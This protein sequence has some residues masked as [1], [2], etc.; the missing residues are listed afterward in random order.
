M[1]STLLYDKEISV[2]LYRPPQATKPMYE[3][4][5][6]QGYQEKSLSGRKILYN[7]NIGTI[8]DNSVVGEALPQTASIE[9]YEGSTAKIF[10]GYGKD[11]SG[12]DVALYRRVKFSGNVYKVDT[13]EQMKQGR[14]PA[15]NT[16]MTGDRIYVRETKQTWTAILYKGGQALSYEETEEAWADTLTIAS[17]N[18]GLKP[19]ISMSISLLPGQ[20]CYGATLK[21]RNLNIDA[22]RIREWTRMEIT[23][24]Y[25]TGKKVKYICPIFTSYIESP[26]PDGVTVFEGITV[27]TAE[28][29]ITTQFI[30]L[31]F[32]QDEMTLY[33]L[34]HQVAPAISP[35]I[36]VNIMI[37]EKLLKEHK[38]KISKQTV[39]SQN[40]LAVLNWLQST[41]GA[42]VE[43]ITLRDYGE[44]TSIFMQL[45]DNELEII[46]LNGPNKMV[47]KVRST[48]NLDMVTGATFNGTALTVEAPWNP[49]LRPGGLFYMPP[50]FINGSRL[51]NV[52]PTS[53][54]R[55]DENLYRA[56][57]MSV[58]FGSVESTNKMTI[59]AV[60]AQ[61]S[62]ELP[63]H[64]TTNLTGESFARALAASAQTI[65][66]SRQ[67]GKADVDIGDLS[68]VTKD[69]ATN[70][71]MYDAYSEETLIAAWGSWTDVRINAGDSLSVILRRYLLE[72]LQGPRL[73]KGAK[74]IGNEEN[75]YRPITDF[76]N[77]AL[78][79]NHFSDNGCW[80]NAVWWPLVMVG[81]YWRW[82]RDVK[83]GVDNKWNTAGPDNPDLVKQD[84][85][86]YIPVFSTWAAMEAKLK[87]IKDIFK[88][89]YQE[90]GKYG[91]LANTW[92]T[93]YYYLGGTSD[94]G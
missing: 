52:L 93:M 30:E 13:I 50:E 69:I 14:S 62:G 63:S 83:A 76:K 71:K 43:A 94:L 70:K 45:V 22:V 81:T 18:S 16:F 32:V 46:A 7:A 36:S 41:V 58:Q 87:S 37:D 17:T 73:V 88:Y 38:V 84:L 90:Y 28:D 44:K 60:P 53:D 6:A 72:D 66:A 54:Y 24:G 59:L 79:T 55:N 9:F 20:N 86:L 3:T 1:V 48:V 39:Y 34:I 82:Q 26:N 27:G 74:G 51:P 56:L 5:I 35:N 89:A 49:D 10:A 78:A 85:Y 92:K 77:N 11:K 19:D 15:G 61:W 21:I 23:A 8:I 4:S 2:T 80:S 29:S 65:Q 42:F 75:Y 67:I 64:K 33:D 40:G 12:R 91:N 25:R 31:R 68:R 57:T 47:D